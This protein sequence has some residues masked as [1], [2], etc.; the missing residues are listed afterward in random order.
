MN[1]IITHTKNGSKFENFGDPK[2]FALFKIESFFYL[3]FYIFYILWHVHE[4]N[5]SIA[6]NKNQKKKGELGA[7]QLQ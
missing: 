5:R 6:F 7:Q 2:V 4:I 1:L 3:L